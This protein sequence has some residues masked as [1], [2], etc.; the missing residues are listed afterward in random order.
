MAEV[1]LFHHAQGLTRGV[2]AFA[3]ELRAAGHTVHT[4]DLFDGHAFQ[5]IDEGLAYIR[6]IGFDA[7]RERG[8]RVANELPPALVY[9]GFSFGVLPAQKL[10]QTRPGAR[11]ALLF[12]SCLPISGEWAFGPWP[13]GVP[14]QIH[15]MDND[16]IFVGEGDIHA[17]REIVEKAEDAELFLYPGDQHYFADS[18]LPSYDADATAL[19]TRRVLEFLA[20]V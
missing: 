11:G 8:V 17:A 18:S 2:H 16:P 4:P 13:A 14:V 10:A 3:D 19:L 5:S 7:M 9:A 20:R 6:K 1:L 15:G 12:Y